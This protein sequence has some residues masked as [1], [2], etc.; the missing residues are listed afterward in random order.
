M[1]V[2]AGGALGSATATG[3]LFTGRPATEMKAACET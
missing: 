2:Y 3:I 1:S